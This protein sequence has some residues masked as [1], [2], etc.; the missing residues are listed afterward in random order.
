MGQQLS[1][2]IAGSTSAACF[3]LG[4][5]IF[6]G[7]RLDCR[8]IERYVKRYVRASLRVDAL[9]PGPRAVSAGAVAASGPVYVLGSPHRRSV[10][11]SSFLGSRGHLR[12]NGYGG[13]ACLLGGSHKNGRHRTFCCSGNNGELML[14]MRSGTAEMVCTRGVHRQGSQARAGDDFNKPSTS[15][16]CT[17]SRF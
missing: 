5:V 16:F 4:G 11:R 1:W 6:V 2:F 17:L 7:S 9:S 3:P 8:S 10:A 12:C 14:L 13:A 15:Q